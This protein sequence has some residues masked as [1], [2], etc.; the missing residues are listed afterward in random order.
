MDE[1]QFDGRIDCELVT[2]LSGEQVVALYLSRGWRARKSSWTGY[3]L[4][5][6]WADLVLDSG[7]DFLLHGPVADPVRRADELLGP[8]REAGVRYW[9]EFHHVNGELLQEFRWERAE[10]VAAPDRPRD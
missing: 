9:G 7:T 8:L 3:E 10:Q 4:Q 5:S 1:V 6:P 2:G